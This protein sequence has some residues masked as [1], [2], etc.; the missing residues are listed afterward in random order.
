MSHVY[1]ASTKYL[2]DARL[3]D[4][5]PLCGY[6]TSA[7]VE[8]IDADLATVTAAADRVLRV[9]ED[10][11]WLLHV[12]LQSSRDPDFADRLPAY[13]ILLERRHHRRVRTVAVL[14]RQAADAPE[15]SG[16]H[17][18]GFPGE[19]PYLTFHYHVVRLWELPP[20]TFLSGGL[21]IVPLA[22]LAAV[23]EDELPAV[24]HRMEE[25]IGEAATPDEGGVLWT[26]ATVLMGL[27]YSKALAA[28]LLR[29]VHGMKDSVTYQAIVEEGEVKALHKI[30]LVQGAKRFGPP[31]EFIEQALR[32]ITEVDRLNDLAGRIL[33]VSSW[34]ELLATD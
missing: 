22:P 14:L 11:A 12:E 9:N 24:V 26:A 3:A 16:V 13:N 29:G 15:L 23:S 6:S 1:D 31:N 25:R 33:D 21:G 4:W 17:Q 5:L 20:E 27:R 10:P 18:R 2:L 32:S 28:E 19:S 8:V 7:Q 34:E 30:L